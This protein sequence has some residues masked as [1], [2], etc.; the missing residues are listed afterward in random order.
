LHGRGRL[1]EFAPAVAESFEQPPPVTTL[2]LWVCGAVGD[3]VKKPSQR[4]QFGA[5]AFLLELQYDSHQ[6]PGAGANQ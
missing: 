6:R 4:E 5:I 3:F 2:Y 1:S